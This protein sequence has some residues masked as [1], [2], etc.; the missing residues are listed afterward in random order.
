MAR[1]PFA[2]YNGPEKTEVKNKD[3]LGLANIAATVV[4]LLEYEPPEE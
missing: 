3:D 4:T 2:V 1:V